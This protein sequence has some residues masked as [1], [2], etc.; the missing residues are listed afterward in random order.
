MID[1]SIIL[2]LLKYFM[3]I[4]GFSI[5]IIY[6]RLAKIYRKEACFLVKCGISIL[7]FYWAGYYLKSI[8]DIA[9]GPTHQIFVRVPLVVTLVGIF[10]MGIL[11]LRKME[12]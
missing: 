9:I 12:R 1:D 7:G 10:A 2:E 5:V 11:S 8:L 4:F 3:V 6:A